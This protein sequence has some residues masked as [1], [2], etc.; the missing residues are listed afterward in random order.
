MA[1]QRV[2]VAREARVR[3]MLDALQL[4]EMFPDLERITEIGRGGQKQVFAAEH[5]SNGPVVVKIFKPGTNTESVAREILAASNVGSPRVPQIYDAGSV[6]TEYGRCSWLREQK[7]TGVTL[8]AFLDKNGPLPNTMVLKLALQMTAALRDSESNSIVHR[9][10][11]PDNIMLDDNGDF[12]LLD[13]GIARHLELCSLT[14]DA[15]FGKFTLGYAPPEQIR[16]EKRHIDCRADMF[17]L[18]ITLIEAGTGRNPFT[19]G[20]RDQQEIVRRTENMNLTKDNFHVTCSSSLADLLVAL[21]K[22]RRDHRPKTMRFVLE[23][24]EEIME[25]ES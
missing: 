22:K 24:L 25:D 17:A 23:W 8:R 15:P 13:F 1:V 21:T 4:K 20:A 2:G 7:I 6:E 10:V 5:P 16:N 18:G 3:E 9:D 14:A 11:K 19:D 12:W